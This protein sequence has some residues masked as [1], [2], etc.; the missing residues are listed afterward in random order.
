MVP[1]VAT[2]TEPESKEVEKVLLHLAD[3]RARTRKAAEALEKAGAAAHVTATVQETE[4]QLAEL[5]RRLSQG[6]YYAV[7]DDGLRLGFSP[8]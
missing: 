7:P 3:V 6:T 4:R 1:T 8:A 2:M 5:H